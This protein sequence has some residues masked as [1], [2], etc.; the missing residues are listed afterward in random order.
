MH[1]EHIERVYGGN[2][3]FSGEPIPF[4]LLLVLFTNRSGSNRVC[5]ALLSTGQLGMGVEYLNWDVVERMRPVIGA[6]SF[7]GH[8]RWLADRTARNRVF[9]L[10][11]GHE[12]FEML[13]DWGYVGAFSQTRAAFCT[14]RDALGQAISFSI[15]DQTKAWSSIDAKAQEVEPAYDREDIQNR[16]NGVMA[17]AERIRALLAR[18]ALPAVEVEYERFDADPGGHVAAIGELIG[19][20]LVYAP[21]R[22]RLRRQATALNEAWRARFL[23]GD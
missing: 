19:E 21:E 18:T 20:R 8:M 5:D 9:V 11:A 22:T 3:A 12:Q 17:E 13:A 23:S 1:R 4:K 6:D 10:K 7:D 15:A 2:V 16:L 14:R